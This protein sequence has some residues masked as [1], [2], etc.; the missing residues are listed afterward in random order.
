MLINCPGCTTRYR[1]DEQRIG[2]RG[3]T[4]RCGRCRIVFRLTRKAGLPQEQAVAPHPGRRLKVLVANESQTFCSAVCKV[5]ENEPFDVDVYHDGREILNA[6]LA[7]RPAVVLLDVALPSMFGFEICEEVRRNPALD[8]VKLILVASIYDRAK[9]KRTPQSLY[10]ADAYIEKHHI[11]DS[12]VP[13]I[14][15]LAAGDIPREPA[16]HEPQP[17]PSVVREAGEEPQQAVQEAARDVIRRDEERVAT[18]SPLPGGEPA[19]AQL[20]EAH[21]KARRLARIIVSDIVLYNQP[22]VEEGVRSGMF[23]ELLADDIREGRA[24]YARR[25]PDEIRASTSYLEDAF[26]QLISKKREELNL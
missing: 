3:V 7:E 6:I 16:Y 1:F 19:G 25:V 4:L 12:L 9:Y 17:Q 21:A 15:R 14:H 18:V 11:S 24:L 22:H 8:D 13:L 20:S 2:D 10:G 26:D 23:Y 5:L